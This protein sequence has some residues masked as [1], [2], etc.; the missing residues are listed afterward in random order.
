MR[1]STIHRA[2]LST[3]LILFALGTTPIAQAQPTSP[4]QA[5]RVTVPKPRDE[6]KATPVTS[7]LTAV[8]LTAITV[9]VTLLPS[10]RGHQD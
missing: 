4:G 6:P 3:L 8:L 10:K 7:I 1:R 2:A 9:T 5:N